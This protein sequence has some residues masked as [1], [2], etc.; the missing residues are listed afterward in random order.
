MNIKKLLKAVSILALALCFTDAAFAQV[1]LTQTTLA[2][3]VNGPAL[4]AGTTTTIDQNIV[5]ASVAGISAPVLPGTPVSV[6]YI[7]REAIG[8]FTVN[9]STKIVGG[10]RGYLGTQAAPHASGDMVLIAQQYSTNS[11]YGANPIP[12][13]FFP[14]DAPLFGGCTAANTPTTPWVNILTA[15][16]WLCSGVTNTW[17]PGFGNPLVPILAAPT[18]AVASVAGATLPSG[19]LFHVTG[20]NAITSW[21]IPIGCNA[22]AVGG[23]SFT[24]IPDAVFTWTAAGNIALAGTA[25]VN[26]ALTFTWDAKNSK[27]VPSY[28]A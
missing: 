24:V 1:A 13:G 10:F 28:I 4:Y 3:Q 18:A 25:V 9:T 21:T 16:Q 20:T 2:S 19:P 17:V 26:K 22:T 12:S 23:C 5:L 27:W 8:V 14:Q 6:I 15:A 7:G 11:Q